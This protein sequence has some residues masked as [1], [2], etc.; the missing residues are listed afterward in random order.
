MQFYSIVIANYYLYSFLQA[1]RR[2]LTSR[3]NDDAR[4]VIDVVLFLSPSLVAGA[5]ESLGGSL[6]ILSREEGENYIRNL[7]IFKKFPNAVRSQHNYFIICS[8]VECFD[9]WHS[10]DA[11]PTGHRV[12][13]TAGHC[14]SWRILMF[15]PNAHW[16]DLITELISV[17]VNSAVVGQNY[18]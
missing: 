7:L 5:H 4:D 3:K 18:L 2:H 16:P 11:S 6:C 10:M 9:F 14:E 17:G 1:G 12:T 8:Q 13:E 15:K